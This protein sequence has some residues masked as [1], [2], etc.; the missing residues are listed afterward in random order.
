MDKLIDFD[1]L[2]SEYLNKWY[3]E[4]KDKYTDFGLLEEAA[5]G[6]YDAWAA[7]PLKQLSGHSPKSYFEMLTEPKVLIGLTVRYVM[8]DMSPPILLCDRIA[9]TKETQPLLV[10]ILEL[11]E[12]RELTEM[13]ADILTEMDSRAAFPVYTEWLFTEGTSPELVTLAVRKLSADTDAAAPLILKRLDAA[14]PPLAVLKNIADVLAHYNKDGRIY[15]ILVRLF[16]EG[17]DHA[18]YA[19]Y[20][21]AYGDKRA[22]P[23]LTGYG[24]RPTINYHQY[25]EIRNAVEALGGELVNAKDFKNDKYYK[26][27]KED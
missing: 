1:A 9:A 16:N 23:L 26:A 7:M 11:N 27:L 8:A 13:A 15:D 25:V 19:S 22:L 12:N 6:V 21:A 3:A 24:S 17:G 14:Q 20:L 4:N 18:L 10:R 2:F 5:A